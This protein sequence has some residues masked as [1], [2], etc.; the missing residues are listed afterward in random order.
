MI[1]VNSYG[2]HMDGAV[3]WLVQ[4]RGGQNFV[5][6]RGNCPFR[7]SGGM[8]N[9][10]IPAA[11][12]IPDRIHWEN[13]LKVSLDPLVQAMLPLPREPLERA[14]FVEDP[15]DQ[16][17]LYVT[18]LTRLSSPINGLVKPAWMVKVKELEKEM[19]LSNIQPLVIV[20][21]T[22]RQQVVVDAINRMV[23]YFPRPVV[24]I[25]G[26]DVVVRPPIKRIETRVKDFDLQE[27]MTLPLENI[28][29]T[30]I[31]RHARREDINAPIETRE[32]RRNRILNER[33][34]DSS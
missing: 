17:G 13:W 33:S 19:Q 22:S 18:S 31:R 12:P 20:Q 23:P 8:C 15:H 16:I 34:T 30:L 10:L 7:V 2:L 5:G 25:G 9:H 14:V 4:G 1:T 3:T 11:A 29:A 28:G 21:V 24:L 6:L 32:A 26:N 27:I